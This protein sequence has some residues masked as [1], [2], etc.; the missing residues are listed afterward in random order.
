[1][2][3]KTDNNKDNRFKDAQKKLKHIE[4]TVSRFRRERTIVRNTTVG[5]WRES[6][7]YTPRT[8][9]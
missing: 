9:N 7:N 2:G 5:K 8:S 4:N 6:D 3:M 1:M